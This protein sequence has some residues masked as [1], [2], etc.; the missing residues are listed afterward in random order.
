M[1]RI[2]PGAGLLKYNTGRHQ[3]EMTGKV[4][5][6]PALKV[7]VYLIQVGPA[8]VQAAHGP[9]QE[10]HT[11][12]HTQVPVGFPDIKMSAFCHKQ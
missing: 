6:M 3:V 10:L 4:R 12:D 8:E 11:Q 1:D 5:R 9:H 2:H 7:A